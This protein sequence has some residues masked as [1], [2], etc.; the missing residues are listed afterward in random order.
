RLRVR[1]ERHAHGRRGPR[2]E[3]LA[4][5][6]MGLR[7]G[8]PPGPRAA[9]DAAARRGYRRPVTGASPRRASTPDAIVPATPGAARRPPGSLPMRALPL[10]LLGPFRAGLGDGTAIRVRRRKARALLAYLAMRPG[11]PQPREKLLA[12]LWPDADADQ[13]RHSLRQTLT[14]L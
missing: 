4:S 12:L 2:D 1:G 8:R 7:H 3:D 9:R 11:E 14:V 5:G 6:R 13:A 10:A